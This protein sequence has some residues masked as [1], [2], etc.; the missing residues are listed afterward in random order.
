MPPDAKRIGI[1]M[2]PIQT[3]TPKKDSSLA[4]LL[5]ASRR[6]FDIFYFEQRDLRLLRGDALGRSRRLSVRDNNDAWFE[7]G[8]EQE[9]TLGELDVILMR[10]DPPFDMEYVYTTY[11]LDRAVLAGS[12]VVNAPQALRDI[13]EKAY[14]AW[15]PE[16]TPLTLMTRSLDDLRAFYAEHGNIVVKPLDGMGGK[17]IFVVRPDDNNANVIF[18]TLTENGRRFAMAQVYIPEI[19]AGDKRILLVDGEPVPY[20]LARIPPANDN[21]GNLVMG[22]TG[23]GQPLSGRDREICAAVGPVLRQRGVLF[24]GLDVIGDY[25][26]EVNVTSP[27]GIRELDR[28]FGLNIAGLLFDAIERRMA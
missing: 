25:L 24:A 14:T 9:V 12:L 26:T 2:D 18:E 7:L 6:K 27:T 5:E 11:L 3:I 10:K 19:R 4:M 16:L 28:Q 21:R 17:S 15:F 20:A 23:K 22:A 1:V 8:S 13:N